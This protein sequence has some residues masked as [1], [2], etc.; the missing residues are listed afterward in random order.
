MD[1]APVALENRQ[2]KRL[3]ERGEKTSAN[4]AGGGFKI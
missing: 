4:R 3:A 2:V 1:A